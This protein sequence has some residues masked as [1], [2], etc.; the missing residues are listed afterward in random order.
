MQGQQQGGGTHVC[1]INVGPCLERSTMA[2][3]SPA[4]MADRYQHA[5]NLDLLPL[6]KLLVRRS[7]NAW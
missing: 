6:S 1:T 5:Q 4:T 2:T 7:S 3:S